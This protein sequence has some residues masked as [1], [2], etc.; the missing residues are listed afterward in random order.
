VSLIHRRI[1]YAKVGAANELVLLMQDVN[2]EM[3]RFGPTIDSR[4]LTDHMTG[5]SDRVL[6]EWEVD[7]IGS[8]DAALNQVMENPEGAAFLGG[9]ME[10]LNSLIHYFEGEFWDVR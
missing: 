8:M 5:R 2:S 9:W 6:V 4:I 1:F 10:K 7:D 3:A